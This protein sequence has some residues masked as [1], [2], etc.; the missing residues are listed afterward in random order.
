MRQRV[1]H[2]AYL[3]ARAHRHAWALLSYGGPD[4]AP[5]SIDSV[6]NGPRI[7]GDV[8]AHASSSR[9]VRWWVNETGVVVEIYRGDGTT[10]LRFSLDGDGVSRVNVRLGAR[11]R[12]VTAFMKC[13]EALAPVIGGRA[14]LAIRRDVDARLRFASRTVAK[15]TA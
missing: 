8:V 11:R 1:A 7:F 2:R 12:H 5:D 14:A 4:G 6:S 15:H 10:V 3:L 13:V 9:R